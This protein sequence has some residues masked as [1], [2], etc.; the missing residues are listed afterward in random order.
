MSP[1]DRGYVSDEEQERRDAD[2]KEKEEKK[3]RLVAKLKA[4]DWETLPVTAL[5]SIYARATLHGKI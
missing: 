5:G 4:F 1:W 2:Q 3:I